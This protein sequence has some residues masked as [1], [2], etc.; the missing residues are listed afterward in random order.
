[1]YPDGP[2][3]L[4]PELASQA[5]AAS[6]A[7]GLPSGGPEPRV[8]AAPPC[9]RGNAR[10]RARSSAS[11]A[12]SAPSARRCTRG[13]ARLRRRRRGARDARAPPRRSAGR[14]CCWP[15]STTCCS[16]APST[17]LAAHVPTVA[18]CGAPRGDAG[19][20]RAGLLPR[21][22]DALAELLARADQTNEVN[23]TCALLPALA[24]TT[25]PGQPLRLVELGAS[26]GLNLLLDRYAYRYDVRTGARDLRR[27]LRAARRKRWPELRPPGR[28]AAP[29][30]PAP[31]R[32]RASCRA[33]RRAADRRAHRRRPR[34]D[35]RPRRARRRA[36]CW[37]ACGPTRPTA[38]PA[39][40]PRSRSR[41][42]TRRPSC[43]A[44][45][46][47]CWASSSARPARRTR[48][49]ALVGAR[50]LGPGRTARADTRDRRARRAP[51]PDVDLPRAAERDAGAADARS[52]PACATT[53]ATARSSR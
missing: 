40:A 41:A 31:A 20:A 52:R 27:P 34:P 8:T 19:R 21:A 13:S 3:A 17:P 25:P 42:A 35:R 49:L 15:R 5:A 29:T 39:C 24:H 30:V 26:A 51:R 18:G 4:P 28:A 45:G 23:R 2:Q 9:A 14:R 1:M 32:S 47:R 50:V 10:L 7:C 44:T 53:P 37:R 46:W 43:A 48:H 22:R 11:P 33:R 36:G 16:A 6:D 38:S 12:S